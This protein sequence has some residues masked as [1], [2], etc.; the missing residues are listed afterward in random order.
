VRAVDTNVLARYYLADDPVQSRMARQVL[1]A[2]DVF[3]P[4]TVM[5]ELAWVLESVAE[6]PPR[7]VQD[8]LRHLLALPGIT[9]E[10]EDEV[11]AAL[12]LCAEGVDFAD[13]L[14][15]CAS[16]ACAEMLTFDDRFVRRAAKARPKTPVARPS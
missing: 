6:Q 12:G 4:K 14:H 3:V 13:A 5:L 1:E 2:G 8:C 10:D 15:L 9:V 16:S 7:K 11:E